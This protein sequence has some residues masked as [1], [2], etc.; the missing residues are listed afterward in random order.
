MNS[1]SRKLNHYNGIKW[2]KVSTHKS[3][4]PT[5]ASCPHDIFDGLWK[6]TFSRN[7]LPSD[8]CVWSKGVPTRALKYTHMLHQLPQSLKHTS[9]TTSTRIAQTRSPCILLR[10]LQ[11]N[12]GILQLVVRLS[13]SQDLTQQNRRWQLPNLTEQVLT[14][15]LNWPL[16]R[17]RRCRRGRGAWR[18]RSSCRW[19][20]R[21]RLE[22]QFI[23]DVSK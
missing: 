12:R 17:S 6:H 22:V 13:C 9:W 11:Q 21:R 8:L 20:C 10:K 1:I 15:V 14:L 16:P 7:N 5:Y 4:C 18:G 2:I 3:K 23:C 19:R